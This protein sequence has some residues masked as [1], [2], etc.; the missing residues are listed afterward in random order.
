[1]IG[2]ERQMIREARLVILGA[3]RGARDIDEVQE[4]LSAM[5]AKQALIILERKMAIQDKES[6]LRS[7]IPKR[8]W[9]FLF[10]SPS[11]EEVAHSLVLRA[12]RKDLAKARREFLI[13]KTAMNLFCENKRRDIDGYGDKEFFPHNLR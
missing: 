10:S 5:F 12:L 8:I 3:A 11:K 4:K 1:M 9:R 6:K 13:V 7:Q 2:I